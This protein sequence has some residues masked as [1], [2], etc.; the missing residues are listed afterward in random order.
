MTRLTPDAVDFARNHVQA[1]WDSDFFPKAFEFYALWQNWGDVRDYLTS[2][3]IADM[4]VVPPRTI[5]APKPGGSYRV[6]HQ[7]DPV[8]TLAYT[9][10]AFMVGPAVES[11]RP[12]VTDEVACSYRIAL[13]AAGGRFWG[14]ANGYS[15]FVSRSRQL[16][17]EFPHVLTTDI[18]DF[19]NQIYLHRL[20]NNLVTAGV[21]SDL[22]TDIERFLMRLNDRVSHGVPVGP[23]ASVVMAEATLLDIDQF[24]SSRGV[25]HT[26]Y[27]DDFHI[28]GT[29]RGALR[30]LLQ[31]LTQYLHSIHRLVLASGK[32]DVTTAEQFRRTVLDDPEETERREI[33]EL[34]EAVQVASRYELEDPPP[35][36]SSEAAQRTTAM[37]TLMERVCAFQP[38]D[39]GLARHVLRRSRRYRVR[40]IIP[41]LFDHF[42]S[43]APVMNDVVL[44]LTAVVN[45]RFV[46][47]YSDRLLAIMESS[48]VLDERFVRSWLAHMICR[49]RPLLEDGRFRRWLATHGDI[50]HQAHAAMLRRDV[51]WV[52]TH[53]AGLDGL[54]RW[55][56]RQVI[57]SSLALARDERR[58]WYANLQ[59]NNPM[60]MDR[61]LVAWLATQ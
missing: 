19:Y 50:E 20:Q 37:Q 13:D 16:A 56:R 46:A 26:R 30:A 48:E 58:A 9:A 51:A 34:L 24:L 57:R 31:E 8:N 10:M 61:W 33:H 45:P 25:A 39:L 11:A 54:G 60:G 43:F 35:V 23:V 29:S 32:T 41:L 14:A 15:G 3:D 17:N 44:Y 5:P 53:R 47:T 22:A 49:N 4:E 36:S 2:T 38:L 42:T 40:S 7:L 6:V 59:A 1:F 28:F 55:Q 52:R 21:A 18:T 12:P 27:V